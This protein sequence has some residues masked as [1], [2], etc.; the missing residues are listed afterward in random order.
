[1]DDF[2]VT[3]TRLS[4]QG[5]GPALPTVLHIRDLWQHDDL[6]PLRPGRP[7]KRLTIRA[8][9]VGRVL[10]AIIGLLLFAFLAVYVGRLELGMGQVFGL[11]PRFDLGGEGNIP[12]FYSAVALLLAG[13]LLLFI[14]RL[15]FGD[16]DRHR[17]GWLGLGLGFL[18]MA[19]DEATQIHE[20]LYRVPGFDSGA[21]LWVVPFGILLLVIGVGFLRFLLNLGP[22]YRRLFL[23]SA[24]LFLGGA[25]GVELITDVTIG[26]SH[27]ANW[28][29]A[30]LTGLEEGLEMAGVALFI[31]SLLRYV[32]DYVGEVNVHF[33]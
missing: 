10:A 15:K 24:A 30:L 14:A 2:H 1:M 28:P 16:G 11:K 19:L 3:S 31:V 13:V 27:V 18:F 20:L 32:T 21:W 29:A 33:E 25:V 6:V 22:R 9:A 5:C 7:V 26:E 8:T 12:A 17:W 4:R 23:L